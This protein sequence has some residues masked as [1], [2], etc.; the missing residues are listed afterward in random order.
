M[1]LET[2]PTEELCT[3][4]RERVR[5]G[6][7]LCTACAASWAQTLARHGDPL[8]PPLLRWAAERARF[9]ERRRWRRLRP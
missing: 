7:H 6:P 1:T 9:F 2:E 8:D 5:R 4:C 3:V